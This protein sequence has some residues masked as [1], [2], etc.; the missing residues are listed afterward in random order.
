MYRFLGR[1]SDDRSSSWATLARSWTAEE[2][3]HGDLLHKY[4]Y[5]SG[6]VDMRMVE[7]TIHYL[8]RSGMVTFFDPFSSLPLFLLFLFL[9]SISRFFRFP[10]KSF[11]FSFLLLAKK[12]ISPK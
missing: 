12:P 7:T 4:L 10:G 11:F 5:L 8:I 2:N 3:R 1:S 6:K 9:S